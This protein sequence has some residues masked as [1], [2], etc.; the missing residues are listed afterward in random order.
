[1]GSVKTKILISMLGASLVGGCGTYV[2]DVLEFWAGPDDLGIKVNSIASQV[3]CELEE[4]VRDRISRDRARRPRQLAWL[5]KWGAQVTLSFT[6]DEKTLFNPGATLKTP[7]QNAI[8]PFPTGGNLTIPQNFSL[9]LGLT[10]SAGAQRISKVIMLFSF[11]EMLNR[12]VMPS[13]RT[14]LPDPVAGDL[15]VT[16]KLKLK[17]WL[18]AA[19]FTQFT[20]IGQ[21]LPKD[22]I[23][24]QIKYTIVSNGGVTPTWTLVRANA[25]SSSSAL[26]LF[27]ANRERTQ[28]LTITLGP[29]V[30]GIGSPPALATAAQNSH[31][32]SE[33][34][35]AVA[36]GIR[37]I[38]PQ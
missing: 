22:A 37:G 9:G 8:V 12:G 30:T 5:E 33:I 6:I 16:S 31:L 13:A 4:A 24:H 7:L 2:P 20:G 15:F 17:E 27:G 23:T 28:D 10:T 3:K 21:L 25:G 14:C 19:T 18:Y 1:M 34:G 38:T 26:P 35:N 11:E 29:V 32:A 36:A